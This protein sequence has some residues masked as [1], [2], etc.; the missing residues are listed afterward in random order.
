MPQIEM[1]DVKWPKTLFDDD[2]PRA[3]GLH[4][5]DVTRSLVD[6]AGLGYK[7]A[8]FTDM[9]LTAEIGLLWE[10]VLQIVMHDKYAIRPPQMC[11]DGIWISPDG[12]G[13]DPKG[14]V[15]L[16]IE[17][18]KATWK[19]TKGSPLDNFNYMTQIKSYCHAIDTTVAIMRI[20]YLMGDYRGSGPIYRVAR[21]VFTPQELD[22]NWQ[23]VLKE[24]ERMGA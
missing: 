17:E 7:G 13:L 23:M 22:Q 16:V 19:S 9:E 2:E 8:G 24:K 20:F 3:E 12:I 5:G 14:E 15:P 18:Y 10:R 11:I 4:L 6:R 1:E 21:I